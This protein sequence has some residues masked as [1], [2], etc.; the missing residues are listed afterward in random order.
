ANAR[1]LPEAV[2]GD[3]VEFDFAELPAGLVGQ[4]R[5]FIG[6]TQ[7]EIPAL[8]APSTWPARG[9]QGPAEY[10]AHMRGPRLVDPADRALVTVEMEQQFAASEYV[11][12]SDRADWES[13]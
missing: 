12:P 3:A 10:T 9:P 1:W 7:G 11:D 5:K 13:I 6:P 2:G 4:A 8:H